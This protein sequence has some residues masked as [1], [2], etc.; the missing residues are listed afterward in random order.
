M[1]ERSERHLQGITNKWPGSTLRDLALD[2]ATGGNYGSTSWDGA[3]ATTPEGRGAPGPWEGTQEDN[4]QTCR[5][6]LHFFGSPRVGAIEINEHMKRLFTK[7]EVVWE[8]IDEAFREG[9]VYHIPNKCRWILVW[10]TKQNSVMGTYS[11]RND[12]DDPWYNKVFR[13]GKAGENMAYTH[14][15]QI[16]FYTTKFIKGLGYQALKPSASANV[17]F[18]VFAGITEQGRTSHSCSP[19][20]GCMMR[21]MDFIVTDLPLAPTKPIDGG[22]VEFCKSCMIC[23]KSCPADALSLDKEPSYEVRDPGNNPGHCCWHMGWTDCSNYGS[24]FDCI[25]CQ[26]VC[27]FNH[28]EDAI[29]HPIIRAVTGTTSIFNGFFATMEKAMGYGMQKSDEEHLDWWYRDLNSWPHDSLLGF[30][31]AGW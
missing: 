20:Y 18:G 27:P 13:Q 14:A 16:R 25:N 28:T 4:L 19:D 17:P 5:A 3:S 1:T 24:P 29:I 23:A 9:G 6:A 21:Y 2:G 10:L 26:T 22:V 11:L 12:P 7:G 30:G 8:D 31:T 15:P